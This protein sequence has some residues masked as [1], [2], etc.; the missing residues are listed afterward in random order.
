M[1]DDSSHLHEVLELFSDVTLPLKVD[2]LIKVSSGDD[3][4][5]F[6]GLL[7]PFCKTREGILLQMISFALHA[8]THAHIHTHTHTYTYTHTH[9][10]IHTHT[11]THT[12]RLVVLGEKR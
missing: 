7:L 2:K 5:L 6:S 11:H 12:H 9:A 1:E 8:H 4:A 10:H 3:L